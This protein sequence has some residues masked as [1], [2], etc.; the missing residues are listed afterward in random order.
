MSAAAGKLVRHAQLLDKSCTLTTQHDHVD[1]RQ[2]PDELIVHHGVFMCEAIAEVDDATPE[3]VNPNETLSVRK[4]VSNLLCL[5]FVDP[6]GGRQR[7]GPGW[8]AD[9]ALRG[10][11]VG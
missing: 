2:R 5:G 8:P 6:G 1:L 7:R 3:P 10:T 9:E 11:A 4:L